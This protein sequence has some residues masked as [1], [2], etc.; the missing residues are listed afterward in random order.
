MTP[1]SEYHQ[2]R[3]EDRVERAKPIEKRREIKPS[4]G[5]GKNLSG[6]EE[7]VSKWN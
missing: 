5:V 1:P 7:G 6:G 2:S 3:A 4:I